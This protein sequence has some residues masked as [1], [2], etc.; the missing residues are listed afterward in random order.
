MKNKLVLNKELYSYSYIGQAI[1]VYKRLTD[2][3]VIEDEKYWICEFDNCKYG[4]DR[5]KKEFENLDKMYQKINQSLANEVLAEVC[6]MDL[7]KFET[8][9]VD[10]FA[11]MGYGKLQYESHVT[12]K[13]GDDGIDGIVTADK[14]GF[15]SIYIQAKSY[16]DTSVGRLDIQKFVGALA[17][18]GAQKGIFIT[19]SIYT[20]EAIAFV[21]RNLNYKIVLIDGNRLA[22]L[23]IEYELGVLTQYIYQVKQIDRDYFSEE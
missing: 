2:I 3:S 18:Q 8:L 13:P 17:V 21:E 5:T 22:D 11:K 23:M 20:K 6:E 4:I 15:D 12:R 10:L 9:I 7:Y 14:L 1:M 19:R 16:N